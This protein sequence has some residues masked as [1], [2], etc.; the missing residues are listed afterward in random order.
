MDKLKNILEILEEGMTFTFYETTR[1]RLWKFIEFCGEDIVVENP[2]GEIVSK[3]IDFLKVINLDV[4]FLDYNIV[5]S[6]NSDGWV[7]TKRYQPNY[8]M[9]ECNLGNFTEL[10]DAKEYCVRYFMIARPETFAHTI[11][12]KM[13]KPKSGT[14]HEW[15]LL[16]KCLEKEGIPVPSEIGCTNDI[17][18]MITFNGKEI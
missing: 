3:P 6:G 13:V 14:M 9:Y 15:Y 17:N 5:N 11:C 1:E 2:D 4:Q 16:K 7:I 12:N 10:E 18:C 8:K